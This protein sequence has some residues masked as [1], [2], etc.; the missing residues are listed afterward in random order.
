MAQHCDRLRTL[1]THGGL[2]Y[3]Q[4]DTSIDPRG[5]MRQVL[6]ATARLRK[7]ADPVLDAGA[8]G[9]GGVD[10]DVLLADEG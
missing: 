3:L 9:D 4:V 10:T 2:G 6:R 7:R 8:Y 1:T 5:V